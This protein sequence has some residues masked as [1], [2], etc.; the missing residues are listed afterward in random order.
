M[1]SIH[2]FDKRIIYRE[3]EVEKHVNTL[4]ISNTDGHHFIETNTIVY[5]QSHGNYCSIHLQDG[6]HILCSKTLKSLFKQLNNEQFIRSHNSIVINWKMVKH[7][8]NAVNEVKLK[9]G[10]LVPISRAR[11]KELKEKIAFKQA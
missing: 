6:T 10:I 7:I 5:L 1:I 2:S 3:T 8:N 4:I 9:G 11:K